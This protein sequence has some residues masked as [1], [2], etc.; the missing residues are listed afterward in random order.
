[1]VSQRATRKMTV[2][3][4][5]T[6]IPMRRSN[7]NPATAYPEAIRMIKGGV[8]SRPSAGNRPT[9]CTNPKATVRPT[10][11]RRPVRRGLLRTASTTHQAKP[12]TPTTVTHPMRPGG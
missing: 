8:R 3:T 4:H 9:A 5:A 10:Q 12:D 2:D 1:M 11:T 6:S 7:A